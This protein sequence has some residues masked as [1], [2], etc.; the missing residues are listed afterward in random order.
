[1]QRSYRHWP[2]AAALAVLLMTSV[3]AP[4][5]AAAC[6]TSDNPGKLVGAF[7]GQ[8]EIE[9]AS[10]A[11]LALTFTDNPLFAADGLAPVAERLPD[12]PLIV[13]PYEECGVYGGT[14]EGT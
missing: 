1:M 14:L 12:Q 2:R 13:L 11:G 4:A 8:A 3:S 7:K 5:F 9:D 6:P 10:A